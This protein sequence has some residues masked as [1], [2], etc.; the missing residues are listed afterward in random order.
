MIVPLD[1]LRICRRKKE[2]TIKMQRLKNLV[3]QKLTRSSNVF[4]STFNS[5]LDILK[6][7]EVE[8]RDLSKDFDERNRLS[9]SNFGWGQYQSEKR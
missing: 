8:T 4:D 5:I 1:S 3:F 6:Q 7:Y 9:V 2:A